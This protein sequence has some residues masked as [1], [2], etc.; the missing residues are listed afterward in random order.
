MAE[1]Y[2]GG[3]PGQNMGNPE[4][5]PGWQIAHLQE[6]RIKQHASLI[7]AAGVAVPCCEGC[8]ERPND[9]DVLDPWSGQKLLTVHEKSDFCPRCC[10][11]PA[12]P[13]YLEVK[14]GTGNHIMTIDRPFKGCQSFPAWGDCCQQE[15]VMYNGTDK[16]DESQ[17]LSRVKQPCCGGLFTPTVEVFSENKE[18]AFAVVEGPTC[19]F[20]GLTEMCC[21]QEFV[22]SSEAGKSADIGKIV[23]IKPEDAM[24]ALKELATDADIFSLK[25]AKEFSPSQK[26]ALLGSVF[27]LDYM[28]F[29]QNSAVSCEDGGIKCT[30]FECYLCGTMNALNCKCGGSGGGGD[31]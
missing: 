21:E 23:K 3:P 17:I 2:E 8:L 9:Y 6:L 22:V 15:S 27:L 1:G 30:I 11:Q 18:S 16:E 20:G 19:C 5:G 24:G 31:E 14:D 29:E 26:L 13:L 10:C 28:F 4:D 7:E 12:H 25:F